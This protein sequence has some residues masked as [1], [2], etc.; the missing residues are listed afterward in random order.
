MTISREFSWSQKCDFPMLDADCAVGVVTESDG[1]K[2]I[3]IPSRSVSAVV[4][5]LVASL[6]A[7]CFSSAGCM[8]SG[9]SQT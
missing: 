2:E 9:L 7:N 8:R 1:L 5:V 4:N 6:H 3:S